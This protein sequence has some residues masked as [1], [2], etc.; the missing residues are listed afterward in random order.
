MFTASAPGEGVRVRA[1][2]LAWQQ[3]LAPGYI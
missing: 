1:G 3:G 2:V